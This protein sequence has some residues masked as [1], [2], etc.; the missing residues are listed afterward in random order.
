MRLLLEI[1]KK[2]NHKAN[3]TNLLNLRPIL[4]CSVA[5]PAVFQFERGYEA[6]FSPKL[7]NAKSFLKV[8]LLEALFNCAKFASSKRL[9][10][11]YTHVQEFLDFIKS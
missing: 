11:I 10:K 8:I 2:E 1:G 3:S 5:T 4:L 6:S 7:K 9:I